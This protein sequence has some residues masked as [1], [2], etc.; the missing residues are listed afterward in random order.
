[1]GQI[2]AIKGPL[3]PHT[4]RKE[5]CSSARTKCPVEDRLVKTF[6]IHIDITDTQALCVVGAGFLPCIRS[7]TSVTWLA[8]VCSKR[9]WQG[10]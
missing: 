4:D 3:L 5:L 2:T 8:Q 10:H 7:G 6:D 9:E 1:M